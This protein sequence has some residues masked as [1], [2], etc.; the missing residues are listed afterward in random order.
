MKYPVIYVRRA[1]GTFKHGKTAM[2]LSIRWRVEESFLKEEPQ[3]RESYLKQLTK[4][5]YRAIEGQQIIA[6]ATMITAGTEDYLLFTSNLDARILK[7]QMQQLVNELASLLAG[8]E[9]SLQYAL[10]ISL[11]KIK[12]KDLFLRAAKEGEL[13]EQSDI[14]EEKAQ[15]LLPSQSRSTTNY[16]TPL[17]QYR[18][19]WNNR[20]K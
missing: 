20:Q 6:Q 15:R 5:A 19:L 1:F 10:F 18:R 11:L 13:L 3:L 17:S 12:G 14:V 16:L 8:N 2:T 7:R 4:D 9:V